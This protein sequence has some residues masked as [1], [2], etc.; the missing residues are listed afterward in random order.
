MGQK[1]LQLYI[2]MAQVDPRIL[3]PLE[4]ER[5]NS[6]RPLTYPPPLFPFFCLEKA[7]VEV[8]GRG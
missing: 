6:A 5:K 7:N 8:E 2:I 3:F 4:K 1:F